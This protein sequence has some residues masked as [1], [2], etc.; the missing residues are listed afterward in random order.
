MA[1]LPEILLRGSTVVAVYGGLLALT[2][3]FHTEE[4][5]ALRAFRRARR[6][7]RRVAGAP[8]TTELAGEIVSTD[9]SAAEETIAD[10][11]R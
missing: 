4:L 6:D 7:P 9:L 5:A 10:E 11:R 8:D 3:F 1:P 2:G